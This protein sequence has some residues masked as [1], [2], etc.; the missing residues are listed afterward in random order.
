[1]SVRIGFIV[2]GDSDMEIIRALAA[3]VAPT[4]SASFHFVRLGGR[5]ALPT[6]Y[7][8]AMVLLSKG[9][10]HIIVIFDADSSE[11]EIIQERRSR[12]ED[13]L[14]RHRLL[15]LVA[16]CPAVPEVEAWVLA[17]MAGADISVTRPKLEL[18]RLAEEGGSGGVSQLIARA[19][20]PA[21]AARRNPSFA[22]FAGTMKALA[23][24]HSSAIA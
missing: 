2:E 10:D 20:D 8:S 5:A 13:S 17:G 1:M 6:A 24:H 9:Y 12:V 15:D 3:R 18:S 11:P 14:R 22:D 19:F 16:V 7:T 21:L 4:E 23:A